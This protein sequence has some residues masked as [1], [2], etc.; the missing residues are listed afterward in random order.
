MFVVYLLLILNLA[1]V[2]LETTIWY[3][4]LGRYV[5]NI[6]RLTTSQNRYLQ[7]ILKEGRK[8]SSVPLDSYLKILPVER[9]FVFKVL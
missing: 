9:L 5:K 8:D 3:N 1:S 4:T 7:L 6:L 2:Q